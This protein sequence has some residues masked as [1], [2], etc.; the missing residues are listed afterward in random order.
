MRRREEKAAAGGGRREAEDGPRPGVVK[1]RAT[2]PSPLARSGRR[3]HA[4]HLTYCTGFR[5]EW[6]RTELGRRFS[7][8]PGRPTA[9]DS[10]GGPRPDWRRP[11]PRERWLREVSA[12]RPRAT[13]VPALCRFPAG[14]GALKGPTRPRDCT[15]PKS[16]EPTRIGVRSRRRR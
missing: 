1:E 7:L 14:R 12:L 6:A 3:P 2:V 10:P 8:P 13:P 11:W 5:R 4:T 9:E 16:R 15:A